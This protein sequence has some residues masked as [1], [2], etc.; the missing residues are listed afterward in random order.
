ME[1]IIKKSIIDGMIKKNLVES[2]KKFDK[3]IEMLKASGR[4]VLK[5]G[6]VSLA[7][8]TLKSGVFVLRSKS[9]LF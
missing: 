8:Q 4:V 5:A 9:Y 6:N 2:G 1:D 7:P 3:A